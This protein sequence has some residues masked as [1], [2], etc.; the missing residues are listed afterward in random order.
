[1]IIYHPFLGT[2][3]TKYGI[4]I[5]IV[6]TRSSKTFELIQQKFPGEFSEIKLNSLPHI[7]EDDLK[8]CHDENFIKNLSNEL[9]IEK[10]LLKTYE[11]IDENGNYHRYDPN[12]AEVK[13]SEMYPEIINQV[14]ATYLNVQTALKKGFSFFLGGG[15]H[16][17][18]SFTGRGFCPLNDIVISIKKAKKEGL[19]TN[20]FVIDIDAHKGDGTA[21]LTQNDP[22]LLTL[23]IH[24]EKGWPLDGP[25]KD[26]KGKLH[27]WFLPNN[28]DIAIDKNEESD[29]LPKLKEGLNRLLKMNKKPAELAIVVAGSDPY[30]LDELP[31]T[32]RLN[33][34]KEQMLER[35]MLVFNF[36]KENNIPQAW[37]MAGGYGAHSYEIYTQ[38]LEKALPL[39][40]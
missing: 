14:A 19:L 7:S 29:Y 34:T 30:E 31:S 4:L 16:H 1:M 25:K 18:M 9:G 21:E 2:Q 28:V 17:A 23:S 12:R 6:D 33:L 37:V 32:K 39:M 38:F 40:R 8:L 13:L 35:D 20:A 11:L 5:P 10:E 24:M 15:M 27:P 26:E 36:L 22:S 3:F